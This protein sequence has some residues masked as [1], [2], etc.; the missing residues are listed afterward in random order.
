MENATSGDRGGHGDL[1]RNVVVLENSVELRRP[2]A[3]VFDYCSDI[4]NEREW[5]PTM[6][7]VELLTPEPLR[8]GVGLPRPVEGRAGEHF[9][10]R[11]V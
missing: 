9:G 8:A 7:S 5:N 3:E 11:Q 4:R 1:C 10:V 2:R 6:R